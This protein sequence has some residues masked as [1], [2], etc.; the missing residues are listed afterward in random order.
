MKKIILL[1]TVFLSVQYLAAQQVT[2]TGLVTSQEDGLPVIGASV[3]EKGTGNGAATDLDGNFS[4]SVPVGA[5]LDFSYLGMASQSRKI[6]GAGKL[7]IVLRTDSKVLQEVVVTAMGVKTE[8]RKLNFAVQSLNA[9]DIA[10]KKATNFVNA[11]HGKV[12]GLSVTNASGSP[13]AG[14]QV[15]IR[16]ISSVNSSQNNEPLFI[17]DGV[18]ISGRGSTASDINPNDIE[19]ITVLKGAAAAALYG[20]DAGNGV[21]MITTK[22]GQVGKVI[23]T[24]NTSWQIDEPTRLPRLQ[25]S[26][27]PGAAGFYAEKARGGWGPLL[28]KDDDQIYDNVKN[29]LTTGFYQKYDVSLSGGSEKFQAYASAN[30]STHKGIVPNDY[31]N[32][33]GLLL[34]GTFQP[35]KELSINVSANITDNTS[36]GFGSTS[37][38]GVYNWPI[39]DDITDYQTITGY[40]RFLYY[41]DVNKYE[42]P[43][44]PLF[45]RYND[46]G[47]NFRRRNVLSGSLEWSPVKKLNITGRLSYDTTNSGYDGYEVSRWDKTTIYS[48]V[49][50][51]SAPG[52]GATPAEIAQYE[53]DMAAYE[54]FIRNYKNTPY[55]TDQDINNMP[56][57]SLG[58]YEATSSRSQ[59]FTATALASYKLEL[60]NEFGIDLLAGTEVRM[61]QGHSLSVAGRDFVIPGTYSLSNT[62]PDYVFLT[63]RTSTHSQRRSFG[64]FGEIRAD[65][66]GLATLS[67]T[68]RWDWTSTL[69]TSPYR[70]PSIT[71]G[72]LFSELFNMKSDI[73]SYGKLRGNLAVVGKDAPSPYLFDRRLKQFATYPDNGYGIDPTLSSAD[74]FLMPEMVSTW[75]AGADLRFFDSRTRLDMAYYSTEVSNQIVT[76]R[77]T[78]TTGHVLQTRN[79]GSIRNQGVE[80]TLEQDIIKN[81]D[82]TW[83]T[84][85]NFGLNRSKVT[86]LPDGVA[87]ISQTQVGDIF[88]SAFLGEST[89]SL[90]GK[91]YLRTKDGKIICD[92]NGLPQINPDKNAYLGNREPKF[93]AGLSNTLNYKAW[94]LSFLFEGR[95]GGSVVNATGRGLLSNGQS[96]TLEEYRGRQVMID[97]VVKQEDGSYAPN[98]TPITLDK[99]TIDTYFG[100]VSSNFVEDGSYMRM[101]YITLGYAIPQKQLSKIGIAGL[102]C[103]LTANNLFMLTRYTGSDP[104]CNSNT[105]AGGTGYG[106]IDEYPVPSTISYNFSITATF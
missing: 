39:N 9:D 54:T 33:L 30:Y 49:P 4:I 75:E 37:M 77:V 50:M 35:F 2:V 11:L 16:G 15:I 28:N 34:K 27:A 48:I 106:G 103:S 53:R 86:Y 96:K 67:V 41:S 89:T 93:G 87:E 94:S 38:S 74:P 18:P 59:F 10:D 20:Q 68:S 22:K 46:Y 90:S 92:E 51:P 83:T 56:K 36:R 26:Y 44:S 21:I 104:A 40:P 72:V 65:Y 47:L 73:F 70:Y 29:F 60:S 3:I 17:L 85:L 23:V 32:T 82:F 58:Y 97:G 69:L 102:R 8:K 71:G 25:T 12:A 81:R 78:H 98:T 95:L 99:S 55:L 19:S 100:N 80:F 101:S 84:A 105:S 43:Y 61:S 45:S 91:D 1:L 13:N 66:K 6:T 79:E 64:H 7:N 88:P 62:N 14:T 76:V 5:T 42:S 52:E 63:D 24:A 57:S 31:R